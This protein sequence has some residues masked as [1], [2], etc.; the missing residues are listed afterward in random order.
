MVD[1]AVEALKEQ[2]PGAKVQGIAADFGKVEEVN[3]LLKQ[4]PEVDILINNVSI[5]RTKTNHR[6]P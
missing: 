1:K 6:D 5:F 4:L 3:A 2:S